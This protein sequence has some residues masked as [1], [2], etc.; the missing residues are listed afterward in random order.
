M[1]FFL[2]S[3]YIDHDRWIELVS[4]GVVA[5][6]GREFYAISTDFDPAGGNDFVR[7]VVLPQLEPVGHPAWMSRPAM[8][9]ALLRFVGDDSPRFW[10][11]GSA[12][13]DWL[14]MVQLMPLA[15]RVPDGWTYTAYD[16]TCLLELA[17]SVDDPELPGPPPNQHHALADARWA[18]DVYRSLVGRNKRARPSGL[19][20]YVVDAEFI[21][22]D[23]E[24][25]LVSLAVVAGDGREFYA[26]SNEFDPSRANDFV[27]TTVLPQLEAQGD[28]VWMSRREI[29]DRLLAFVGD[30]TPRFWSW[31]GLP[32]DWMVIAQL[33]GVDER[34]PDGWLYTGYDITLLV[35]RAGFSTDPLDP[36]LPQHTGAAHHALSDAHWAQ[37][38][39]R[40]IQRMPDVRNG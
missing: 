23:L 39:L 22:G 4:L 13:W 9:E 36:R 35:N 19:V 28:P 1:D 11:Y 34:M 25:D 29:K 27:A 17:G 37:D 38:V 18:R 14:G 26:V 40:A 12:P 6:D 21:E 3:E 10:S 32:Y 20:D 2:N 7:S 31:G 24:I 30:T 15:E 5:A 33:F 8:K 16:V